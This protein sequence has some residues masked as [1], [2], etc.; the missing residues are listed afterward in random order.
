MKAIKTILW[1]QLALGLAGGYLAFGYAHWAATAMEWARGYKVEWERVKQSPDYHEPPVIR[2]KSFARV[3]E[4]MEANARHRL[5]VAFYWLLTCGV[6]AIL[7]A[8]LLWLLWRVD[9]REPHTKTAG[10]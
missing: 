6:A 10:T 8:R 4:D 2:D 1:I 9:Q 3:V 7:A 5:D